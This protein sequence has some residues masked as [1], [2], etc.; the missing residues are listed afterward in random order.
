MPFQK[1]NTEDNANVKG[2][3]SKTSKEKAGSGTR[4]STC[5]SARHSTATNLPEPTAP[6]VEQVNYENVLVTLDNPSS[7]KGIGMLNILNTLKQNYLTFQP[8][9]NLLEFLFEITKTSEKGI[10]ATVTAVVGMITVVGPIHILALFYFS[11]IMNSKLLCGLCDQALTS[12]NNQPSF[13]GNNLST[14]HRLHLCHIGQDKGANSHNLRHATFPKEKRK[15][16]NFF[17]SC[18]DRSSPEEKLS[19]EH[20]VNHGQAFYIIGFGASPEQHNVIAAVLY[21]ICDQGSYINWLAV[22]TN[23][24]T[25][26]P[27]G[28]YTTGK[29][30]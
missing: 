1:Q 14:K 22:T 6:P 27:Y 15:L 3:A 8:Y 17:L 5:S 20:S 26:Q 7:I 18:F 16:L 12:R 24:F 28:K 11:R 29:P 10:D 25:P 21:V 13:D 19:M 23:S 9:K 30:F 4:K 2:T